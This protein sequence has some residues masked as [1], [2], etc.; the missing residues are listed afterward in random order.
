MNLTAF[1]LVVAAACLHALWNL[2]AKRWPAT[3]AC[4]GWACVWQG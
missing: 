1:T 2:A 3:S 4:C